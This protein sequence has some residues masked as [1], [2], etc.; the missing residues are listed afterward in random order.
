MP[1]FKSIKTKF[2]QIIFAA[3]FLT[4]C[5]IFSANA[6]NLE[7]RQI[8]LKGCIQNFFDKEFIITDRAHFLKTIRHD[9]SRDSCLKYLEEIDFDK[10]ALLGIE[11]N[12]GY[13]RTP[14]G[15]EAQAV[16]DAAKKQ[17][18]LNI[19]YL[20]PQGVCRALRRD[21]LWILV[22]KLPENYTVK[23]EVNANPREKKN[24]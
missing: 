9:A 3:L 17:Y 14:L 24:Q 23:Y 22:P 15:L 4:I 19:S 10:N 6:E 18:I 12:T 5:S 13:C 7:T 1:S 11:L 2:L 20:A 21:D 16:K 8:D